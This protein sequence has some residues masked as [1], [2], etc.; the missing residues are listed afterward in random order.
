MPA[1]RRRPRCG[2]IAVPAIRRGH[3]RARGARLAQ[4]LVQL[5]EHAG[6]ATEAGGCRRYA[7]SSAAPGPARRHRARTRGG[8]RC[9]SRRR[10]GAAH[11]R[12]RRQ[13]G[14][15]RRRAAR[16]RRRC[17]T[18]PSSRASG[19]RPRRLQDAA[20]G[21]GGAGQHDA[22]EAG[23]AWRP[24]PSAIVWPS[25]VSTSVGQA[26]FASRAASWPAVRRQP[27]RG[28]DANGIAGGQRLQQ[29]RARQEQR[30][31]RRGKDQHDAQRLAPDF[32]AHPEQPE[33]P[34]TAQ[35]VAAQRSRRRLRSR[36]RAA[37][38]S[39]RIS[40]TSVSAT[41]RQ[42]QPAR[43]PAASQSRAI[44]RRSA[45]GSRAAARSPGRAAQAPGRPGGARVPGRSPQ[46]SSAPLDKPSPLCI[47]AHP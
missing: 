30:V 36:K 45:R 11:R 10:S 20:A 5:R 35:D 23:A 27:G 4:Q 31:V 6:A 26:G 42:M 9:R 13:P 43:R 19:A 18:A 8:G 3:P 41:G 34:A 7:R 14:R 28:L 29:L 17:P 24:R 32:G 33:R 46:A 22:V 40:V 47:Y 39:G 25:I 15:G 1:A 16:R 44:R 12:G 38:A 21:G 37:S 2:R